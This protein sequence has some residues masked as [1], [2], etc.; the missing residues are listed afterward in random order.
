VKMK[1]LRGQGLLKEVILSLDFF[2]S[3]L[4][5][6]ITGSDVNISLRIKSRLVDS[7]DNFLV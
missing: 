3:S 4:N 7:L 6:E 1:P 2:C 5:D